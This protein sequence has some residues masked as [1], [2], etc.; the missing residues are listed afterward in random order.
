[1]RADWNAVCNYQEFYSSLLCS[2]RFQSSN[3]NIQAT[4]G[5]GNSTI[6]RGYFKFNCIISHSHQGFLLSWEAQYALYQIHLLTTDARDWIRR[7]FEVIFSKIYIHL[8][9]SKLA[10]QAPPNR[11][12][13]SPFYTTVQYCPHSAFDKHQNHQ[14][15]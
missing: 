5:H 11:S 2:Y 15:L 6:W 12:S 10:S 4:E 9:W 1:M 8:S 13:D 7:F 14:L 3:W